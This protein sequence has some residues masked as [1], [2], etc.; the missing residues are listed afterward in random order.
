[1]LKEVYFLILNDH[2]FLLGNTDLKKSEVLGHD[3]YWGTRQQL[4]S[5]KVI[6]DW[7]DHDDQEPMDPIF[8]VLLNPT[9]GKIGGLEIWIG[10]S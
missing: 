8:G 1:M 2:L 7:L 6:C 9:A 4:L 3:E 5:G 10:L